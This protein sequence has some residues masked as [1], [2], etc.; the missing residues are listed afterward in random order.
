M[1]FVWL[2]CINVNIN[3]FFFC[4]ALEPWKCANMTVLPNYDLFGYDITNQ[5]TKYTA[6]CDWCLQTSNCKGIVWMWS[7]YTHPVFRSVCFL[8]HTISTPT[9]HLGMTGAYFWFWL[10]GG[11]ILHIEDN[12]STLALKNIWFFSEKIYKSAICK[13]NSWMILCLMAIQ[14]SFK[15]V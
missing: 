10:I 13:A 8:K 12:G 9:V 14:H 15:V 2:S 6:C 3:N 5:V 11:H 4:I 7:N 1:K